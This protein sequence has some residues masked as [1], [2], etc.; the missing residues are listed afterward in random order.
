MEALKSRTLLN[1]ISV[2]RKGEFAMDLPYLWI[3]NPAGIPPHMG[4]SVDSRYFSLKANGLDFNSNLTDLL[5]LISRKKLPVLAVEL[6]LPLTNVDCELAF[7]K[8]EKTIPHKITCLNPIKNT[9]SFPEV[10]KLSELLSSLEDEE[11]IGKITSWNIEEDSIELAEY[12]TE[13][14]HKHLVSLSK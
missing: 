12:S 5:E 13:D 7:S 4:L 9:L 1:H 8:F 3:W 2:C 10:N 6:K 11:L 14:I